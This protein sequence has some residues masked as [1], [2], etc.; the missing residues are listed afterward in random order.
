MAIN[1]GRVGIVNYPAWQENKE[2]ET[3]DRV[4]VENIGVFSCLKDHI[5]TSQNKPLGDSEFWMCEIDFADINKIHTALN[6]ATS[7]INKLSLSSE[8]KLKE[9]NETLANG[10]R[11]QANEA[12]TNITDSQDEATTLVNNKKTEL[13][14]FIN[15]EKIGL[16]KKY[17]EVKT[18]LNNTNAELAKKA[19]KSE[20]PTDF[21]AKAKVDEKLNLKADK[22][23]LPDVYTKAE[24]DGFLNTKR[25]NDE[26]SNGAGQPNFKKFLIDLSGCDPN[27][28][29][30]C[31]S[32]IMPA[33]EKTTFKI[34][35]G[36][37]GLNNENKA[38]W[39]THSGGFTMSV[40]WSTNGSAWGGVEIVRNIKKVR[41][42]F[43]KD[44][45]SPVLK[46]D[47][48]G[49]KSQE[50]FYLRGGGRY[51]IYVDR[52]VQ[53][54]AY[55]KSADIV[56]SGET[57][58]TLPPIK[59]DAL[60]V[61]EETQRSLIPAGTII[62]SASQATPQGYLKCNGASISR[63]DYQKLFE[64]I[65]ITFGSDD[66]NSFKLPDLRGRF[67]RGFSDGSSIDSGR[68]FGS[69]QK[70]TIIGEGYKQFPG[71]CL[72]P[73]GLNTLNL[74]K[75][76]GK[77]LSGIVLAG[78]LKDSVVPKDILGYVRPH[79]IALNFYIKY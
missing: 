6:E 69:E 30:P 61:P 43:I 57:K 75:Y 16:N 55:K 2:Y 70:G 18:G 71:P 47:Q 29:F 10:L 68:V 9:T 38:E 62:Q 22:S 5:A 19:D 49:E 45:Q 52:G 79:N 42:L 64:A 40:E 33:L 78:E 46:I 60:L 67:I 31:V 8:N 51:E 28:Y 3:L 23:E 39:A 56:I 12:I 15:D 54:S 53:I 74:D 44:N 27:T 73:M 7:S 37:Y 59:Y 4:K 65:G 20:L 48:V 76:D 11:T 72:F 41:W 58:K 63:S 77:P 26:T 24:L 25:D 1:I 50:Y 13:E 66:N 21:Y 17:D 32:S 36:L 35:C 14:S 34:L